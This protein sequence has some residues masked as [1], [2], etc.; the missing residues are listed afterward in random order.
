MLVDN[1]MVDF[2]G[3]KHI[4][5]G[6]E[7]PAMYIVSYFGTLAYYNGI[8]SWSDD[9]DGVYYEREL[10]G[11]GA[12]VTVPLVEGNTETWAIW[13]NE[14][15]D[16][17]FGIY[18]PNIDRLVAIRHQY[19]GSKDPMSNSTSYVATSGMIEMV[20][21]FPVEYQYL[22]ATGTF[23]DVRENFK[24]NKDFTENDSLNYNKFSFRVSAEKFDMTDLDLTVE[25]NE[26]VFNGHRILEIGYDESEGATRFCLTDVSDPYTYLD[27][28]WN[29]D[30]VLSADDYNVFEM[31]YMIPVT[32]SKS[33]YFIS[34]FLC[35]GE[36]KTAK[37]GYS[38]SSALVVDGKYHTVSIRLPKEKWSGEINKI[39]FDIVDSGAAGDEIFVKNIRLLK[40]PDLGAEND[41][42]VQN[43][44]KLLGAPARTEIA[45]SED[46]QAV[47]LK[48]IDTNDVGVQL[49]FANANLSADDYT[50]LEI[51]YMMPTT[52]SRSSYS[53]QVFFAC[54]NSGFAEARSVTG[55]YAADG[56][57]HT[58]SVKLDS[59]EGWSGLIKKIR[60]DYFSSCAVD[61]VIYIKAISFK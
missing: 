43:A 44:D 39:R 17:C 29:S 61:D 8:K 50:T 53:Y 23:E 10:G 45:Y 47:F 57:Y 14:E 16:F 58:V 20:S 40:Y 9:M 13:M 3:W 2:S 19:D 22:L 36:I 38:V 35:A 7:I 4:Q 28:Y 42:T 48:V 52:N 6:Q 1:R 24:E 26:K 55:T 27:F 25:G 46:E 21:Y 15:D 5:G 18:T 37:D 59:K 32:N 30:R 41:L 12:S 49:D 11:W 34:L 54:E 31:E 60:F 51:T 33:S 56:E